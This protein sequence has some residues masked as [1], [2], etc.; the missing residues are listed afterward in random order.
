MRTTE[1]CYFV[2]C[3]H[4]RIYR[5]S[6]LKKNMSNCTLTQKCII[7]VYLQIRNKKHVCLGDLIVSANV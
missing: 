7:N 4:R 1:K 3:A 6:F 2:Y 5:H